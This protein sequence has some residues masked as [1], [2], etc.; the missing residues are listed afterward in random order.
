MSVQRTMI[1]VW[2]LALVALTLA[3]AMQF[4]R[5]Q[6]LADSV[7]DSQK[8]VYIGIS[9]VVVDV[10]DTSQ[11][12]A[13][14][15]SGR[16][17]LEPGQGMLFVFEEE[18]EHGIW[19]KDMLFSID[20]LWIAGDGTIITIARDVSP[21]TYPKAFHAS[22]PTAKYVLEVP[23]GYVDEIGVAVGDKVVVK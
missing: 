9:T 10:A 21:D 18:G 14:G 19:M 1:L 3:A 13:K 16:T 5:Q 2:G 12:H 15:L 8:E 22:R 17:S 7:V 11:L 6:K 20:I 23:A 4:D